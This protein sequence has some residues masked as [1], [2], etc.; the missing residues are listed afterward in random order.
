MRFFTK[1]RVIAPGSITKFIK[2][3]AGFCIFCSTDNLF[4]KTC[5]CI[6]TSSLKFTGQVFFFGRHLVRSFINCFLNQEFVFFV[7]RVSLVEVREFF[8]VRNEGGLKLKFKLIYTK[9]HF[10][11]FRKIIQIFGIGCI[12]RI[13]DVSISAESL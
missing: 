6:A 10:L 13:N 9:T 8:F 12:N 1:L 5:P 2:G 3:F 4:L 11:Y 7:F